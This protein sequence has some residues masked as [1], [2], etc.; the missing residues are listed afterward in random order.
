VG[1]YTFLQNWDTTKNVSYSRN[2][3]GINRSGYSGCIGWE[4]IIGELKAGK[5][6]YF[7]N[8]KSAKS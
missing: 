3:I 8:R 6:Y 4:K 7:K 2:S 5:L 1:I